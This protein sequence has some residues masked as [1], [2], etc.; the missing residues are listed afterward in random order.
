MRALK[1][2]GTGNAF[3]LI[4]ARESG[5][6]ITTGRLATWAAAHAFDQLLKLEPSD[7]AD[8][9]YRI[10]N[11]DGAEVGACG[12]GARCAGWY[13]TGEKASS[14]AWLEAGY[15][16][17]ETRRTGDRQMCVDLGEAHTG[18]KDIPLTREMDTVAMDYEIGLDGVRIGQ[19]GVVSMGNPHAVFVVDDVMSLPIDVLG[20]RI[21]ADPLFPERVNAGF[22]EIHAQDH[23][24]LRVWER[25]AGLTLACG[26]GAAAAVVTGHR[27]GL[28][29]RSCRV[30]VDGG[31]LAVTWKADNHV[32]LEGPVEY[33]GEVE[34]EP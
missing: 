25:G 17:T 32:W 26:T 10:W 13:L 5:V 21:E 24:R 8:A 23:I 9:R 33:E 14:S 20:P 3:L 7:K 16:I 27:K 12:N 4:D 31:E 29:D 1:M 6:E 11:R 18:W 22:M 19:P 30:T 2:N 28:L 34:L 15:G